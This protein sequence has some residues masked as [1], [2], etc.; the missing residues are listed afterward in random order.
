MHS[1]HTHDAH[2]LSTDDA[3]VERDRSAAHAFKNHSLQ[4]IRPVSLSAVLSATSSCSTDEC[5]V[6]WRYRNGCRFTTARMAVG[7]LKKKKKSDAFAEPAPYEPC[8][9]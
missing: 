3:S 7:P 4:I 8:A 1:I 6:L 5:V 9:S 2:D